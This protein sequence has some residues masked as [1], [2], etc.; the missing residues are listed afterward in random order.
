ML[1]T[2]SG[3]PC[4]AVDISNRA[5]ILV[6]ISVVKVVVVAAVVVVVVGIGTRELGTVEGLLLMLLLLLLP[7]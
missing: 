2:V 6:L 1:G 7:L 5:C 3:C 4:T